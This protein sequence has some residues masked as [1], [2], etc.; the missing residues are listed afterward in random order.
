MA[1]GFIFSQSDNIASE[2]KSTGSGIRVARDS[3]TSQQQQQQ[4]L[5]DK[6][7]T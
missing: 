7:N 4:H 5:L 3:V 2:I 1:S 6:F